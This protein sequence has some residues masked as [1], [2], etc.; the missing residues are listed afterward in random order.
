MKLKPMWIRHHLGV[1]VSLLIL[2]YWSYKP[3]LADG[4]FP[5]HD[6]TQVG[7]VVA[8]GR[9]LRNGQFPVRWVSDLGYGFGYPIFNFYGPLPYYIGG[10]FYAFG[11]SGLLATKFMFLGGIVFAGLSMYILCSSIFGRSGGLLASMLYMYAPYHAV[12][13]YVRG[14]VGEF[15]TLI[16]LPLVLYGI[17]HHIKSNKHRL[18]TIL[19][20]IGLAGIILSHTVVGYITTLF[21]II[22]GAVYYIFKFIRRTDVGGFPSYLFLIGI[23]TG[24]SAFFWMPALWEMR[25]SNVVSQIGMTARYSDHFVCPV[26]LWDS[27][28]GYGGSVAGCMDGMS[29]KLGK[30]HI[31]LVVFSIVLITVYRFR[32]DKHLRQFLTLAL[33]VMVL[34]LFFMLSYSQKLWDQIPGFAYIQYPWRF[35]TFSMV[36]LSIV[37]ASMLLVV[38]NR[39]LR[40]AVVSGSITMLLLY[41]TKLFV[42]QHVSNRPVGDYESRSELRYRVSKI[43]DEYM[44]P[45]F[46]PP[47]TEKELPSSL[48][49]DGGSLEPEIAL[50]QET[51]TKFYI[52]VGRDT[53]VTL[54]RA[55]FPGWHYFINGKE[56][57]PMLVHSMP[58]II[59]P[60]GNSIIELVF[61]NTPVRTLGNAISMFTFGILIYLYGKK[62]LA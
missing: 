1:I 10:A 56:T 2:S 18:S 26:Q 19:G 49:I 51:Y 62:P 5:I 21:M 32:I 57:I 41:N 38:N 3:L 23:G 47:Q 43:S 37:G 34:S 12:E 28:W 24:L 60:T 42:P 46:I 16:F 22:G 13:I 33:I 15:W 58:R 4:Y 25:Y 48:F 44:P 30:L 50:N 8:M 35:L 14:A 59:L 31:L 27:L 45:D 40:L 52:T 54:A 39:L 61:S 7:R 55:Y 17:W 36:S 9:A 11:M 53:F 6:D 29:F 20:G